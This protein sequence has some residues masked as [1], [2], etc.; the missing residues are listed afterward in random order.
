MKEKWQMRKPN[1]F[2]PFKL[3]HNNGHMITTLLFY[4]NTNL[5]IPRTFF[6]LFFSLNNF[7]LVEV[8]LTSHVHYFVDDFLN[9]IVFVC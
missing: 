1:K 3:S 6:I 4:L 7:G 8:N 9:Y 5:Q 2:V